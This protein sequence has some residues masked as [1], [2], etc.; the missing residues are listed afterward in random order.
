MNE[1]KLLNFSNASTNN[2]LTSF[3]KKNIILHS[4]K[5]TI[6]LRL[7]GITNYHKV[8]NSQMTSTY[9]QAFEEYLNLSEHFHAPN[10]AKR[11]RLYAKNRKQLLELIHY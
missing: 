8:Y 3:F 11:F 1:N 10:S 7:Y 5:N 4:Q 2:F 9:S 6:L